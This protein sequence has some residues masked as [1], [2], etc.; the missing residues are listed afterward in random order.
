MKKIILFVSAL[1]LVA[2]CSQ[3]R[4]WTDKER[5]KIRETV[6]DYRDR[7]AIRAMEAANYENLEECVVTTLEETY[8]DY[9]QYDK[10]TGQTDTLEGVMVSCLGVTLGP[11]FEN[12]PVLFPA[13]QLQQAGILPAGATDAQVQ[14]FYACLI[15]K[16][17]EIYGTPGQFTAA[18]FDEAG[19]PAALAQAM[20]AC[21]QSAVTTDSTALKA[22]VK[23]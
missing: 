9:N 3:S 11:N 19:D 16:V 15:T 5:E 23:K 21:A 14:S 17:K 18:L 6:R 12:L 10:L 13:A 4:R 7:S 2:S 8:P 1:V 20:Q 22:G